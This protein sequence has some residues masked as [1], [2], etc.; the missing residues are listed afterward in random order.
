MYMIDTRTL[1][2]KSYSTDIRKIIQQQLGYFL[3][4]EDKFLQNIIR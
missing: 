1:H 4:F 2:D 3:R